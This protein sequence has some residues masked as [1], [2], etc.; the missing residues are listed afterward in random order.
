MTNYK[1]K[2]LAAALM[3]AA[4]SLTSIALTYGASAQC[5][6]CAMY[7]DRDALNGGAPTAASK[8]GLSVYGAAPRATA[9]APDTVKNAHAEMRVHPGRHVATSHDRQR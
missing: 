5:V 6:E 4:A 3:L 9:A 8:M 7:P 1:A 2:L